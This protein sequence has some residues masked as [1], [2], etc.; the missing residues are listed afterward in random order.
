MTHR[1]VLTMVL[2]P[3]L[4]LAACAP[5]IGPT[6]QVLPGPNKPFAGFQ[7]DQHD[8]SILAGQTIRPMLDAA[9]NRALG[10]AILSTALGAGLGAA[11]GGGRGAGIGAASG[12]IVGS[13][14]GADSAGR[15]QNNIQLTYDNT[16]SQCM[17]SR[18]NLIQG[19]PRQVIVQPG[20]YVVQ[21]APYVAQQPGGFIAPPSG[22][23]AN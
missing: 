23:R 2:M 10:T 11:V 18:G 3:V 12:G 4:A 8:C 20:P 17:Y 22:Q 1:F 21:P 15:D 7:L 13:A 16:Y 19:A 14:I 5:P 9:G 6:V